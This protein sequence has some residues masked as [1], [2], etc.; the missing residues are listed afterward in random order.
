M[1]PKYADFLTY[2]RRKY[3]DLL[4]PLIM[5]GEPKIL[6]RKDA[7]LAAIT[8]PRVRAGV[9]LNRKKPLFTFEIRR[10]VLERSTFEEL[11]FV[12]IHELSHITYGHMDEIEEYEN[13]EIFNV[14]ADCIINDGLLRKDVGV[15]LAIA[16]SNE[17]NFGLPPQIV[18][19]GIRWKK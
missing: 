3:P 8:K 16:I 5:L 19:N 11:I 15:P 10:D 1:H 12:F 7:H 4:Y 18:G 9:T 13:K 14:A 6:N 2:A 17:W